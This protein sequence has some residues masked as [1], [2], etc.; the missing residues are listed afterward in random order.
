M[1]EAKL[2]VNVQ[3]DEKKAAKKVARE[4]AKESSHRDMVAGGRE[5]RGGEKASAKL[6]SSL[7]LHAPSIIVIVAGMAP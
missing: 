5:R 7:Y 6:D 3:K 1:G 4:A 2:A